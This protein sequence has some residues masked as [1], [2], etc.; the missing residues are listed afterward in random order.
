MANTSIVEVAIECLLA[1]TSDRNP[2]EWHHCRR[3]EKICV[4]VAKELGWQSE[5]VAD[6]RLAALLH[7]MDRSRIPESALAA[8]VAAFL[9]HFA[10]RARVGEQPAGRA[11]SRET[12]G[13]DI[14]A[15]ADTFDRLVSNQRY[16]KALSEAEAIKILLYDTGT[17]FDEG[18]V[19]AFCRAHASGLDLPEAK[20][21]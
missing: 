15:V 16:R 1:S 7:H 20:A 3:V 17:V 2:E 21:A 5:Q 18:T 8:R 12:Q 14:I 9:H 19:Q 4:L 10:K 13:A 6:L 11:H